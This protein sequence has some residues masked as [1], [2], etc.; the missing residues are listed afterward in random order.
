MTATEIETSAVIDA[1]KAL[2]KNE[3]EQKFGERTYHAL[4]VIGRAH[5]RTGRR[6]D[7]PGAPRPGTRARAS[8]GPCIDLSYGQI[9]MSG[10]W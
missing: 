6:P 4:G 9:N 7:P 5:V 10:S 1:A 3:P 2:T 8:P